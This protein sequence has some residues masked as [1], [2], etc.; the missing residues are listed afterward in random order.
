MNLPQPNMR[1]LILVQRTLWYVILVWFAAATLFSFLGLHLGKELA[2][3]GIILVLAATLARLIFLSEFFRRAALFRNWLLTFLLA[4][5]LFTAVLV[6]FL[7][8]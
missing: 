1:P 6:K 4:M 3:L 7:L 2:F 5:I 8:L